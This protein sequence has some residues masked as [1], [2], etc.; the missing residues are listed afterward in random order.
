MQNILGNV[1]VIFQNATMQ[2]ILATD[3]LH[4]FVMF[5]YDQEQWSLNLDSHERAAGGYSLKDGN[6]AILATSKNFSQLNQQSNVIP[7]NSY[8]ESKGMI[9]IFTCS[10]NDKYNGDNYYINPRK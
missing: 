8:L 2:V 3:G 6:G 5:N 7:G 10:I 4:S 9:E 1:H